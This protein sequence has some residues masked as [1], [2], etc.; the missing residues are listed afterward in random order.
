[1]AYNRFQERKLSL[2][3]KLLSVEKLSGEKYVLYAFTVS[4]TG[5]RMVEDDE[6]EVVLERRCVRVGV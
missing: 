6:T 5:C 4:L 1:M 3:E 2:G